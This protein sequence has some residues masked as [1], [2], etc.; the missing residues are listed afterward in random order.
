MSYNH[1]QYAYQGNNYT[2][3]RKF[4]Y[5]TNI[6]PPPPHPPPFFMAPVPPP[7]PITDQDFLKMFEKR[8]PTETVVKKSEPYVISEFHDKMK[9]LLC[10]LSE[11]KN[12]EKELSENR[13]TYSDVEWNVKI[14]E[15]NQK[16][17][18]INDSL[19]LINNSV[20]KIQKQLTKRFAKRQ[21]EKRLRIQRK[22][23]REDRLKKM[24][25]RSR[26]IDENLQKIKDSINKTKQE[27]EAKIQADHILKEV[28]RKKHD[29]RKCLNKLEALKKLHKARL[30]TA[31][32][33]GQ[34]V[35]VHFV[36][37]FDTKVENIKLLWAQKLV[38]YE[39][40]ESELRQKLEEES[41]QNVE[42]NAP[43]REISDTLS[44]WRKVLFG[45]GNAIPQVD[46]HG[47]LN[48]FISVRNQWDQYLSEDG[49]PL[50]VG[51]VTPKAL[52]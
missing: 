22:Q 38:T 42:V 15:I 33:R 23:M 41:M 29:A 35:S 20:E 51:W 5:G 3:Q 13:E 32:G 44:K 39:K 49:T 40:E 10:T 48:R 31:K 7:P 37:E 18:A 52:T 27:E 4:S 28:L 34:T 43:E 17:Q 12:I 47:D 19:A 16:K 1:N 14:E 24:E 25:E 36:E 2:F 6:V 11:L 45:D 9:D 30:N 50:P 21:R 26:K 8:L 46:F